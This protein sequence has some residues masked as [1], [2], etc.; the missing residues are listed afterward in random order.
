MISAII[1]VYNNESTLIKNIN[2][3]F[4]VEKI[5]EIV[6]VFDG[7][8][9]SDSVRKYIESK[10]GKAVSNYP[11]I[12]WGNSRARNIGAINAKNDYLLFIDVDHT[13]KDQINCGW[14]N[15]DRFFKFKRV[16]KKTEWHCNTLMMDKD[17]FF[18]VGGY[19]E[20]FC[21]HYGYEDRYMEF[22]L[23]EKG[24]DIVN[25]QDEVIVLDGGGVDIDRDKNRN[26][27][28]FKK[29]TNEIRTY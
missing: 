4:E 1:P 20:R 6:C 22:R 29:L 21:G 18:S 5:S 19:D 7:Y 25:L 15:N 26:Q 23:R 14:L 28:L 11:N 13:I 24:Y 3:L 16:L 9:C 12:P 17:V 10:K 2:R 27:V 8:S